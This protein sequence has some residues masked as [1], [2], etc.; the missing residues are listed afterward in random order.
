MVSSVTKH[1]PKDARLAKYRAEMLMNI[2]S[3]SQFKRKYPTIN[4]HDRVRIYTKK[5]VLD[6][7]RVG[8]WS[9]DSYEVE[10]ITES[11][12]QNLYKTTQRA[13]PDMRHEL[14]RIN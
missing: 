4:V 11:E 14:L 13:R 12:G 8:V 9:K 5:G 2:K 10:R 6:K 7:D 1:T 3:Q